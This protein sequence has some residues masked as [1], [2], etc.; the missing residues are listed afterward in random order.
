MTLPWNNH[1]SLRFAELMG[2]EYIDEAMMTIA[3]EMHTLKENK[4]RMPASTFRMLARMFQ[5]SGDTRAMMGMG[6]AI[7]EAEA[8]DL[9]TNAQAIASISAAIAEYLPRLTGKEGAAQ[10]EKKK[11]ASPLL[12]LSDTPAGT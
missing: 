11:E 2:T 5:A 8:F 1:T 9:V 10:P 7:G 12:T 6:E 4:G 3:L